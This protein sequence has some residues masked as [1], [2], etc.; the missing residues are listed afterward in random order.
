M[1][2]GVFDSGVGGLTVHR[3][4]TRRFPK[5]DFVYLADQANAPIGSKTGEEIVDMTRAGWFECSDPL[6]ERLHENVVW[7]MRGN[8]VDLPTDCPQRDERREARRRRVNFPRQAFQQPQRTTWH[9]PSR[10]THSTIIVPLV[11]V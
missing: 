6:L 10:L 9:Q 3:E 7:S 4:L 1:A 5:R 2:I 11:A 8:F